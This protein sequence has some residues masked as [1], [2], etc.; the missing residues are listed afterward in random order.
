MALG[1][2]YTGNTRTIQTVENQVV[3]NGALNVGE[4]VLLANCV[5][6]THEKA[7][8][9]TIHTPSR[10]LHAWTESPHRPASVVSLVIEQCH[11]YHK[12]FNCFPVGIDTGHISDNEF[13]IFG[14]P[15]LSQVSY[16]IGILLWVKIFWDNFLG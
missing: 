7:I 15:I 4:K 5:A 16:F 2:K 10:V 6:P 14:W 8:P 3:K 9:S 13:E 12:I 11:D 1:T